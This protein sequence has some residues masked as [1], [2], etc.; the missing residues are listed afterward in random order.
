MIKNLENGIIK[1]IDY[2]SD[3]YK[4]SLILRDKILRKPLGLSIYDDDLTKERDDIIFA[5]LIDNEIIGTL[6]L[7]ELNQN[8]IRMRQ[9]AVEE[10]YRKLGIGTRLIK[11]AEIYA[12]E[13]GY[14]KMV[15]HAR[16]EAVPFYEKLAYQK[17][18]EEFKEVGILHISMEKKL[19]QKNTINLASRFK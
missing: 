7:A 2:N 10:S 3:E 4:Q 14:L 19:Q 6:L 18:G 11:F 17:V 16:M 9:V 15:L 13:Q 12:K 1:I 8:E 5:Y